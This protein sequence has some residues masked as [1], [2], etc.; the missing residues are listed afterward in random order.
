MTTL[1]LL[2]TPLVIIHL[3]VW[4]FGFLASPSEQLSLNLI[5]L[6]APFGLHAVFFLSHVSFL[7]LTLDQSQWSSI[8]T[9]NQVPTCLRV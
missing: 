8:S 5:F 2:S 4:L 6:I 9:Q 3:L 7:C 1:C